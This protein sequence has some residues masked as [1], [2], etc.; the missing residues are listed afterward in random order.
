MPDGY[1][2]ML[3]GLVSF[4]AMGVIHKLGDRYSCSALNISLFTM[5]TSCVLSLIYAAISQPASLSSWHPRVPLIALPFGASAAA[6]LWLFQH[7]LRYGRI[8]TSWLLIN[9][10]AAVPTGLSVV[11]YHEPL[12]MR[13]LGVLLLIVISLLLLWWDRK[14]DQGKGDISASEAA[15]GPVAGMD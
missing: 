9:L 4:A 3:V 10:S 5:A 11:V 1:W 13:K 14:Q 2:F 7:G 8:A 12:N 6:A 15:P